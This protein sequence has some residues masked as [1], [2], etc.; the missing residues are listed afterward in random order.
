MT[1]SCKQK[2]NLNFTITYKMFVR[3]KDQSSSLLIDPCFSTKSYQGSKFLLG[4]KY[5]GENCSRA[6]VSN[7]NL[8][9]LTHMKD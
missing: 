2:I 9:Q 1:I 6:K 7:L 8:Y 5:L 3:I 4:F